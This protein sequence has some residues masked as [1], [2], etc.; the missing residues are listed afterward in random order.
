MAR[1]R[2]IIAKN[3]ALTG[4]FLMFSGAAFGA[5]LAWSLGQS[6]SGGASIGLTTGTG[7]FFLQ[8]ITGRGL[9]ISLPGA[10]KRK[11]PS[12]FNS[13]APWIFTNQDDGSIKAKWFDK[14]DRP[15]D[16]F[17]FAGN[18]NFWLPA[19]I[20]ESMMYRFYQ[21]A[22][23]RHRI[24][25]DPERTTYKRTGRKL[26]RHEVL[27]K[28]HYCNSRGFVPKLFPEQFEAIWMVSA[29]TGYWINRRVGHAG[30]LTVDPHITPERMVRLLRWG[31]LWLTLNDD[32]GKRLKV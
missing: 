14:R 17:I 5:S 4:A 23:H 16:E 13:T 32:K 6:I 21:V 29:Y 28:Q 2:K 24:V 26:M 19:D 18:D 1:Q 12:A 7:F 31:W 11:H 9:K 10:K 15:P 20:P 25:L 3:E 30:D 8:Q 22:L 27:S